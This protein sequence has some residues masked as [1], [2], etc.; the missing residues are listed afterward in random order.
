MI[1]LDPFLTDAH[2]GNGRILANFREIPVVCRS[3][4]DEVVAKLK[5]AGL[6]GLYVMGNTSEAVC[7]IPVELNRIGMILIGGLNPVAAAEETG[8]ETE[9]HAMSTVIDY[10]ELIHFSEL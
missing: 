3:T 7:E 2:Q 9:T 4:T 1:P 5:A 8:I 6:G 10:H